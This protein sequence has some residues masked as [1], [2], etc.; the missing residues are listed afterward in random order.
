MAGHRDH[1]GQGHVLTGVGGGPPQQPIGDRAPALF[2]G[3]AAHSMLR[4]DQLP[5]IRLD[6]AVGR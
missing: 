2:A 6:D 3:L 1:P 5:F 4:L